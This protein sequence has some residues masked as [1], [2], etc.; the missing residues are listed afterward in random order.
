MKN[1]RLLLLRTFLL[2]TSAWNVLKTSKDKKKKGLFIGNIIGYGI[3]Y[4][5]LMAYSVL[6]VIGLGNMGLIEFV[7]V[8][9]VVTISGISLVFTFIKSNS[10]LFGFKE[11]DMIVSLPFSIKTVV[12]DKF[13]YMYIKSLGWYMSISAAMLIGYAMYAKPAI[14]AYP[15]WIVLSLFVPIIPMLV[16]SLFGFFFAK[17]STYFKHWKV[18]Q[19]VLIFALLI[20]AFLSR[21]FIQDIIEQGTYKEILENFSKFSISAENYYPI[22]RW[23]KEG[24][25]EFDVLSMI[26]LI[27]V[28]FVLFE[29]A[30]LLVSVSYR[31]I[32][33][34]ITA[35]R[36]SKHAYKLGKQTRRNIEKSVALKEIKRFFGSIVFLTNAGFGY[37]LAVILG[38]ASLFVGVEGILGAITQGSATVSVDTIRISVPF[39]IYLMTG[40]LALTCASPSL[41]GKNYWIIQSLPIKKMELYRGKILANLYISIPSQFIGTLCLSIA[42]KASIVETVIFIL[43][44]ILLCFFSATVGCLFGVKFIKLDWEN[45]VEVVK[46]GMAAGLY[47]FINMILTVIMLIGSVFLGMLLNTYLI[48]A[49]I[50]V[51]Y[52]I[53]TGIAY[54]GLKAIVKE[55]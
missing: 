51:L 34:A 53:L 7:P 38:V 36:K 35:G 9:N 30:F 43:E 21:F 4:L 50:S 29:G 48:C 27:A 45:E 2:S 24:V 47:L 42:A 3:L 37:L 1:K 16:A 32:N 12:G 55:E 13:L 46:Q 54:V 49:L 14:W 18:V 22:A 10:Y 33:T 28:S 6:S 19:V 41:E 11:Y 8:L 17:I 39:V 5:M 25:M 31:K 44:G 15:V 26:L 52:L 20:V 23:F 40:M